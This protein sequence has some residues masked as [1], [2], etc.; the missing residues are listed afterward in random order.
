MNVLPACMYVHHMHGWWPQKL[1]GGAGELKLGM[2]D[3]PVGIGTEPASFTRA[4]DALN[5]RAI[6]PALFCLFL[7]VSCRPGNH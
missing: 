5:Y 7:R 4:A 2:V 6:S 1:E 3:P